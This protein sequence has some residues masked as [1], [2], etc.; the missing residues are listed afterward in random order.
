MK[1]GLI[2]HDYRD[3]NKEQERQFFSSVISYINYRFLE[4]LPKIIVFAFFAYVAMVLYLVFTDAPT[5]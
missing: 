1:N 4:S 3:G 5:P 2:E